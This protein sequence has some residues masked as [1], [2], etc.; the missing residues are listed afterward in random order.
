LKAIA[1]E[2]GSEDAIAPSEALQSRA[3][4]RLDA[5][6]ASNAIVISERPKSPTPRAGSKLAR[7]IDLLERSEGATITNLFEA[8]GWLAH[9]TRGALTGLRK[10]GYAVARERVEGGESIYRIS[11][12]A[13]DSGDCAIAEPN[14]ARDR[15]RQPKPK[16]SRAA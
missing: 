12:P 3:Q 4:P 10:R 11:G 13:T 2:D 16:A 5:T 14:T 9:T 6:K 15:G 8:T 1:V 7:V